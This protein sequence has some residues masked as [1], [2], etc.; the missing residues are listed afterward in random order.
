MN[1]ELIEKIIKDYIPDTVYWTPRVQLEQILT[2]HLSDKVIVERKVLE[3]MIEKYDDF[4]WWIW[5]ISE[6]EYYIKEM[7]ID[8]ESLLANQTKDE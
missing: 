3:E 2:N 6:T 8:I 4:I 7:I 5:P 1:K